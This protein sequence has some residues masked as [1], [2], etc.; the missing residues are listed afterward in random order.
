M[1]KRLQVYET[2]QITVTFDPNVC[3][4]SGVC[5]QGLPDV[6]DVSRKR[7]IRPDLANPDAVAAQVD[8]CPSGA[9]QWS[10]P[11]GDG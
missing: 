2:P 5:V 10:R 8:R 9:L 4:H 3:I 7:W 1:T 11:T 6:F